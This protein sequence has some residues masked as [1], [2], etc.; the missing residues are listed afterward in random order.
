MIVVNVAILKFLGFMSVVVD[1]VNA[2]CGRFHQSSSGVCVL[3]LLGW[4]CDFAGFVWVQVHVHAGAHVFSLFFDGGQVG[5]V[6]Q[7]TVRSVRNRNVALL[8]RLN[9]S[10]R[11]LL[12][13]L[14]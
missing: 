3:L 10:W 14:L 8:L 1:V 13:N 11:I 2:G 12:L 5:L 6:A 7:M 4:E 9:V